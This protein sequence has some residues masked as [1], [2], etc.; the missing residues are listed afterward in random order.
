MAT[1][2]TVP[3]V[4]DRSAGRRPFWWGI[5][6][7]LLAV[8]LCVIQYAVA[9]VL[10]TPWYLPALTTVGVV[11]L[12][13]SVTQRRSVTRILALV[14]VLLLAGFEWFMVAWVSRLPEYTGPAQVDSKMPAFRTALAD[15]RSFTDSDLADGTP[16]VM[17][18]FR[19]RW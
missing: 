16:T 4:V 19:G 15:G 12:F 1:E 2:T 17:T 13:L 3:S 10:K 7:S 14:L 5:T 18:F 9:K 8:L 6:F 11:L